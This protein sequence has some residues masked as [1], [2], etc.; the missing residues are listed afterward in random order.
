MTKYQKGT[1]ITSATGQLAWDSADRGFFTINTEGTKAVVGFAKGKTQKLGDVTITSQTPYASIIL[2]ALDKG[3]TL[4]KSKS[5]LLTVIARA[6][7]TGFSYNKITGQMLDGGTKPLL[8]EPVQADFAI[9]GRTVAAV[10]ILNQNGVL[11]NTTV[12][13]TNGSFHVDT[14]TDKTIYYQVVFK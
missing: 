1:V 10:N 9:A 13:V 5:A 2:T 8:V 4:A 6:E 11:T 3:T 14:G 12:P 7:S